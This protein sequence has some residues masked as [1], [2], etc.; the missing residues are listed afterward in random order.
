MA[1]NVGHRHAVAKGQS[2]TTVAAL[3]RAP[4]SA[5]LPAFGVPVS[6]AGPP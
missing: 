6:S 1:G 3:V 4:S 2:T 5:D